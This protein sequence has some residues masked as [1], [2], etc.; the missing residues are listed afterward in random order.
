MK[1]KRRTQPHN[2]TK[3]ALSLTSRQ[4]AWRLNQPDN[5]TGQQKAGKVIPITKNQKRTSS[6]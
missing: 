6:C 2:S 3:H 5:K 1:N 4:R